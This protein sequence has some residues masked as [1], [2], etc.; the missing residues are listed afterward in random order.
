VETVPEGE[1]DAGKEG[2]ES[3]DETAGKESDSQGENDD[4]PDGEDDSSGKQENDPGDT[5][6]GENGGADDPGDIEKRIAE[7]EELK[8]RL[9]KMEK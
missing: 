5:G 3:E 6:S 4:T 7:L 2:A 1:D 9:K 8:K